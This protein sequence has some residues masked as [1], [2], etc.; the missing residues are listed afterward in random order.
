LSRDAITGGV[1]DFYIEAYPSALRL[2]ND[3]PWSGAVDT[4][5]QPYYEINVETDSL[6]FYFKPDAD[7]SQQLTDRVT[8]Y[9]SIASDD[10]VGCRV[11]GARDLLTILRPPF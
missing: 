10:L 6:T 2:P 4:P 9:R 7:Y 3:L 8:L 11:A 5:F 1:T